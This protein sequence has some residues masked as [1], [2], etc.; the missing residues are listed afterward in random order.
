MQERHHHFITDNAIFKCSFLWLL[1]II[2]IIVI[3]KWLIFYEEHLHVYELI[4]CLRF[5]KPHTPQFSKKCMILLSNNWFLPYWAFFLHTI[6]HWYVILYFFY[7]NDLSFWLLSYYSY[8]SIFYILIHLKADLSIAALSP[9]KLYP[10][11]IED[12]H[13]I[14][15]L[16]Q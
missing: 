14:Y 12:L 8:H 9:F 4:S 1:I 13:L 11:H 7:D 16:K 15:S 10:I 3:Q 6:F 2:F 5:S